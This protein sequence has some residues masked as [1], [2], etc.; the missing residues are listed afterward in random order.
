MEKDIKIRTI[1]ELFIGIFLLACGNSKQSVAEFTIVFGN[2]SGMSFLK[3][4]LIKAPSAIIIKNDIKNFF[5]KKEYH[6]FNVMIST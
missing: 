6:N 3:Q 4:S 2:D 5:I 1:I